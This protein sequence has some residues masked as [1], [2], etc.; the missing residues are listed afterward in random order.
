MRCSSRV[1][2][3]VRD[4]CDSQPSSTDLE[5]LVKW[6]DWR[7]PMFLQMKSFGVAPYNESKA[8]ERFDEA[9]TRRLLTRLTDEVR[10]KLTSVL[11]QLVGEAR[12]WVAIHGRPSERPVQGEL[13]VQS[14]NF[15]HSEDYRS[16]VF[17]GQRYTATIKQA[18]IIEEL[19]RAHK[20]RG[21][22][23][24]PDRRTGIGTYTPS[25]LDLH[26]L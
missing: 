8:W 17:R 19:H 4:S 25:G 16:I 18:K 1:V 14:L 9:N 24:S 13:A 20:R 3:L 21:E 7:A 12:V 15:E 23:D 6:S 26:T 5:E 10:L 11:D 22:P 2:S